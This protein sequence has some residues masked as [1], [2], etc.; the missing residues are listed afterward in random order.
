MALGL[1]QPLT[2]MGTRN[3]LWVGKGGRY[4]GMKTDHLHAQTVLKFGSLNIREPSGPVQI[5]L[6]L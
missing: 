6:Y 5:L 4:V 1:T 2:E 3:I